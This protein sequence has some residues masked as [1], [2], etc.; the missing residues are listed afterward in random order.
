MATKYAY[1]STHTWK[2]LNTRDVDLQYRM[3]LSQLWIR[4]FFLVE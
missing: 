3:Q 1:T 4:R 2:E